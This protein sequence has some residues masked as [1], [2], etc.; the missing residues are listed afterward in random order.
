MVLKDCM[1]YAVGK[2]VYHKWTD[3]TYGSWL[4]DP[5]PPNYLFEEK[6]WTAFDTNNKSVYEYNDRDTFRNNSSS[7]IY[8]LTKAFSVSKA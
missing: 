5:T 7:H 1:L 4:K 2:P 6:V 8:T 3:L